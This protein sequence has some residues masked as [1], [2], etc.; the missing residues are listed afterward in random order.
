M[1]MKRQYLCLCIFGRTEIDDL[2]EQVCEVSLTGFFRPLIESRAQGISL[3]NNLTHVK[4]Q[5][6]KNET[7]KLH[8]APYNFNLSNVQEDG[9]N[10]FSLL[11]LF[12]C[13]RET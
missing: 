1:S 4:F 6:T 7:H 3:H 11:L 10:I 12:V 2:A 8:S 5:E 13:P 9:M